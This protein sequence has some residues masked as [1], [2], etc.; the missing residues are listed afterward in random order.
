M[1]NA[2]GGPGQF[3]HLHFLLLDICAKVLV[4][5]CAGY[6]GYVDGTPGLAALLNSPTGLWGTSTGFVY[7]ADSGNHVIRGYIVIDGS[8]FTVL[9]AQADPGSVD[10]PINNARFDTPTSVFID[11]AYNVYVTDSASNTVRFVD[12]SNN[13]VITIVGT[14][15]LPAGYSGDAG[16]ATA[17]Q[18]SAP[19]DV[20]VSAEGVVYIADMTFVGTGAA[21]VGSDDGEP[22]HLSA[23]TD[24][25]YIWGD[26]Y[27]NIYMTDCSLHIVRLANRAFDYILL[28]LAGIEGSPGDTDTGDGLTSQFNYPSG[29]WG[30]D[31][32]GNPVL[33]VCDTLNDQVK[34][35]S[36]DINDRDG[37][38]IAAIETFMA[39]FNAP[40]SVWGDSHGN[41]FVLER[42]NHALQVVWAATPTVITLLVGGIGPGTLLC[43]VF[44][45][46]LIFCSV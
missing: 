5:V 30:A 1:G 45:L 40:V 25:S 44:L 23:I 9:G 11:T 36:L 24:V 41:V 3:L 21:D 26:G 42:D 35:L 32:G 4:Y 2:G 43:A 22:A 17:A 14:T 39:G 10:G 7:I 31:I 46:C 27:G 12:V 6:P 33:Y 20:F 34:L 37:S 8:A 19:M 13:Y 15:S 28:T 16:P 18:L 38:V 29:L